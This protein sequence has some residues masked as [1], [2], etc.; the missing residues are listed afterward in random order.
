MTEL[1]MQTTAFRRQ[2]S[3]HGDDLATFFTAMAAAQG[4]MGA[5]LKDAVNPHF[6]SKYAD[7][8]TVCDAVIPAL[9]KHGI[10]VIQA[11]G[12]DGNRVTLETI[13]AH[14]GGA[15]MRTVLEIA[16]TKTD[17][18][19][20][21]SAITYARRYALQSVA[22]VAPE[23]EDGNAASQ[24]VKKNA[25]QVKKGGEYETFQ[26]AIHAAQTPMEAALAFSQSDYPAWPQ[27]FQDTVADKLYDAFY[28]SLD[29][30]SPADIKDW[31]KAHDEALQL[32]P[33]HI[34]EGIVNEA[35]R[36]YSASRVAA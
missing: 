6:K 29:M 20:V 26:K 23:D 9:N 4:D 10:A 28:A 7:L 24:P 21:G 1:P 12:M 11:P 3:F 25:S 15:Y 31:I 32:I 33:E 8:A 35:K 19:G 18:Q 34:A 36:R 17:P 5:V 13:L 22:G 30:V 14:K 2:V 27:S 16:P